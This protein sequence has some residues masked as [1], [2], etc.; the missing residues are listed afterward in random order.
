MSPVPGTV[1]H[2]ER[3]PA[4]SRAWAAVVGKTRTWRGVDVVEPHD[5][6]R[7][8]RDPLSGDPRLPV[9][10]GSAWPTVD[11]FHALLADQGV[12]RGLIG[13][14]EV[15]RLWERH[16][17]NSAA[18]VPYLP[19]RGVIVDLGS[20]AGLPGVVVAAMLPD[21]DVVLLEPMERRTD[22]LTEVV[23]R[24]ELAHVTVRR[25]RAQ[26]VLDLQA[27]A[28]TTRAVASLDKLYAWSAPLLRPGGRLVA[29]KG[30][31]AEEE[32]A[33]ARRAAQRAKLT[34]VD[35]HEVAT[36]D[37]V[38]STRVVVAQTRGAA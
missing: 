38:E 32:I 15:P 20:G 31:R 33:D 10:F 24:L 7:I 2:P 25:G 4:L 16:L 34:S 5:E 29:L 26:E 11:T 18:V 21:A 19:E 13:P 8:E 1:N 37:D 27:D 36:L 12:L 23:E 14:R 30:G 22:W 3:A 9:F 28:V 35:L 6:E 17:L